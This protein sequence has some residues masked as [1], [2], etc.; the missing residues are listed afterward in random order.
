[1]KLSIMNSGK[2]NA[3]SLEIPFLTLSLIFLCMLPVTMI[4]PVFKDIIKDKLGGD[5]L[6][7]SYFMSVAMLG[8]FLFS[9]VAGFLSDKYGNRKWF[10][11]V[12]S[13][14]DG[15][16]FFLLSQTKDLGE[17][18][19]L[20][21]LEGACHIFVIGLLLSLIADRENDPNS[22]YH[23]KGLLLGIAGMVLSLGVGLGS[24]LGILGRKNPDIPFL[25]AGA[26]MIFIG[27]VSLIF[28]NDYE[29]HY[30]KKI[31]LKDWFK[32]FNENRLLVVPYSYNFI[33]RFTVGFFV[34][35]FNLHLRED[36]GLSSGQVGIYLSLVLLP[37]SI[38][39]LPFALLS[40]KTGATILVMVGSLV[41]GISL[42][43]SGFI[44][45]TQLLVWV[46]LLCGMGAGV[47]FVPSMI[48]AASMAKRE[49]N[50]SVMAGFTGFGS[51]GFMLGPICSVFL[52]NYLQKVYKEHSFGILSAGF[53]LLEV[54]I[55]IF[56]VPIYKRL[57]E[58]V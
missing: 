22:K 15:I 3:K 14:L 8:S 56:T 44:L 55:V 53:G 30:F 23:R 4:V 47:M 42:S 27:L 16:L 21:F 6:M 13:F 43:I 39:S 31:N 34:T 48:M 33:D 24:P 46:L 12:F 5:N 7:V 29:Y 41:Y 11:T 58:A 45:D 2:K 50:A 52:L 28:L 54:L 10:I 35:S 51:I 37:M 26:L 19:I 17:L 49:Y 38:F 18:H 36:L 1:M 40:R 32:A 57:R 20:R 9:P 25:F